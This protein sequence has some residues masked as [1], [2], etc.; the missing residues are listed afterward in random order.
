MRNA[1]LATTL[2]LLGMAIAPATSHGAIATSLDW[3]AADPAH[4][5]GPYSPTYTKAGPSIG[6]PAPSGGTGRA[7]DPM[8]DAVFAA[9][10]GAQDAVESLQPPDLALGQVVPFELLLTVGDDTTGS[11]SFEPYWLAKTSS[12]QDFGFD[13]AYGLL[14]AFV[15]TADPATTPGATGAVSSFAGNTVLTGTSNEQIAGLINLTGLRAGDRVV[16]EMWVVLKSSIAP[17]TSGNVQTGLSGA[18]DAN[19]RINTGNQTVPLLQVGRFLDAEADMSVTKTDNPDPVTIGSRLTWTIQAEN[20]STTTVANGVTVTDVL[21]AGTTFVSA[22]DPDCTLMGRTLTCPLGWLS[23]GER[24]TITVAADVAGDAPTTTTGGGGAVA[25]SAGSTCPAADLCNAV[26]I[27]S[28]VTTDPVP[29]NDRYVQ[30]TNVIGTDP[31]PPPSAGADLAISKSASTGAAAVGDLVTY[32]LTATNQGSAPA[33]GVVLA[34]PLPAGVTF[35]SASSGCALVSGTVRCDVGSLAVGET[36]ARSITVR[37]DARSFTTSAT[38][39]GLDVQKTEAFLALEA[40]ETADASLSCPG[41]AVMLDGS[42]RADSVDQD[43]GTLADLRVLRSAGD[44]DD[45]ATYDF[46]VRSNATGRAQLHLFGVCVGRRT[47]G[48]G[49]AQELHVSDPS[50]NGHAFGVG[51]R[52]ATTTCA[53]GSTPVAPG[54]AITGGAARHAKAA[55]SSDDRTWSSGFEVTEPA[56]VDVSARCLSRT[57]SGGDQISLSRSERSVVI[58]PGGRHRD[59]RV[60]CQDGTKGVV[61]TTDL[62]PGLLGLGSTPQPINRDFRLLNT[63]DTEQTAGIGLVCMALDLRGANPEAIVNRATVDGDQPDPDATD[64]ASTATITVSPA[65]AA[66][67][68]APAPTATAATTRTTGAG[69]RL[70]GVHRTALGTLVLRASGRSTLSGT[71]RS[72]GR[73]VG[74]VNLVRRASGMYTG[75]VRRARSRG[76]RA[77]RTAVTLRTTGGRVVL[78][79]SR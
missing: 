21:P 58:P 52:E 79:V 30:P 36:Q 67:V 64:D 39:R 55:L 47:V 73:C 23:P 38:G 6:C 75:T 72:A 25:G 31:P 2:C 41:N 74:R 15:D 5:K 51:R 59:E 78:K 17:G 77:T 56:A 19:G 37:I 34:D 32:T 13:P 71:L 4:T 65:A 46:R 27:S 44:A 7:A 28:P 66:P 70:A 54:F 40:G 14:C 63:A 33:T 29:G 68:T 42:A 12:G 16:V 60:S 69:L 43:T 9:P 18:S 62:P 22:S 24:V 8:G 35:V 20:R 57:L 76:C 53:P 61:A 26:S 10:G 50:T 45:A 48:A 11:L 1:R 49:P 3:A